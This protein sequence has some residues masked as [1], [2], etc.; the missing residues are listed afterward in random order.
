M[1]LHIV[2]SPD[3]IGGSFTLSKYVKAATLFYNQERITGRNY[4]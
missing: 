2:I 4:S 1:S 3:C